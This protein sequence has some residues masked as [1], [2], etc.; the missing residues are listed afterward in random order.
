LRSLARRHVAGERPGLTLQPTDLVN[1]AYL[2]LLD[3]KHVRW[4]DREHFF[5]V[6][7]RVMR[8]I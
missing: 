3:I 2:R 7:V 6:A 8:R 5:A 1:E 4:Q